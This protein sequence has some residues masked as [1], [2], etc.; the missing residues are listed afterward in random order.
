MMLQNHLEIPSWGIQPMS[1][2]SI[3][4]V[5]MFLAANGFQIDNA[6]HEAA[7]S[8]AEKKSASTTAMDQLISLTEDPLQLIDENYLPKKASKTIHGMMLYI[9]ITPK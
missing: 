1:L 7:D 4:I 5:V 6:I 3:L 9:D 8:M 2:S